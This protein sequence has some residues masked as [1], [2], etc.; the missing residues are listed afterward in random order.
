ML[1]ALPALV[2]IVSIVLAISSV[3]IDRTIKK[4]TGSSIAR[5]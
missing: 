3:G 1:S 5:Q 4:L 2:R